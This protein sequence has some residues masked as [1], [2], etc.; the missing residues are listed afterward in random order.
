MTVC[1]RRCLQRGFLFILSS[2]H[3]FV[4]FGDDKKQC[5]ALNLTMAKFTNSLYSVFIVNGYIKHSKADQS[6][7]RWLHIQ[8]YLVLDSVGL[9]GAIALAYVDS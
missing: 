9:M 5:L 3:H 8:I 7:K 6:H 4:F 1:S 2:S